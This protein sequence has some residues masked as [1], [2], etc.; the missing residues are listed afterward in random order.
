MKP[1]LASQQ[2]SIAIVG[3]GAIGRLLAVKAQRLNIDSTVLTR[4][5]QSVIF[6]YQGLKGERR[7]IRSHSAKMGSKLRVDIIFLPLKAYQI[8]AA[9]KQLQ[10]VLHTTQQLVLLHNGMGSI[11][12][13]QQLLPNQPFIAATTSH[14]AYIDQNNHLIE[15]GIGQS[16]IGWIVKPEAN[17]HSTERLLSDLLSPCTWHFDVRHALW[18]K[19]AANAIINPLTAIGQFKNGELL[20]PEFDVIKQQLC[21][22]IAVVMQASG[23]QSSPKELLENLQ[24]VISNSVN[25]HSSMKQDVQQGKLTE[26]DFINGY[27][28]QQAEKLGIEAESN[29]ALRQQIKT[30]SKR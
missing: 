12:I 24:Q 13:A 22:E 3:Q 7:S 28:V 2:P 14:A 11:E 10:P 29:Y 1:L 16:D 8:E 21:K 4:D 17:Q 6:N 19:L 15:T 20:K 18:K 9:L 30:L 5:G 23:Y 27:V 26:I 25:N